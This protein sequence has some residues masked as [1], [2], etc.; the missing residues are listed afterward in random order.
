[1]IMMIDFNKT[2]NYKPETFENLLRICRRQLTKEKNCSVCNNAEARERFEMGYG[3][4]YTWCKVRKEYRDYCRG[5]DCPDWKEKYSDYNE[6][7][8]GDYNEI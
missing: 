4:A 7:E 1:M 3:V 6:I 5:I 2:F 8:E